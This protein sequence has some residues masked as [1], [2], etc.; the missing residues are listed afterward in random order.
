M[1]IRAPVHLKILYP[2]E[3]QKF[4]TK[5]ELIKALG[6]SKSAFYRL[7]AEK[8]IKTTPNLIDPKTENQLRI[9]LGF[10]PDPGSEPPVGHIGMD[11][12]TLGQRRKDVVPTFDSS[13]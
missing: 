9:A 4:K 2:M 3:H 13:K 6:L 12:D 7:L 5:L 10:S 1:L 11:W 8:K